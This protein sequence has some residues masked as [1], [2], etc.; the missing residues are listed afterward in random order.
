M[1]FKLSLKVNNLYI[2]NT[3]D[4]HSHYVQQRMERV[5]NQS[6]TRVREL[7]SEALKLLEL[8]LQKQTHPSLEVNTK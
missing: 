3:H 5:V 6:R 8:Y 1:N 2:N 7:I 4:F